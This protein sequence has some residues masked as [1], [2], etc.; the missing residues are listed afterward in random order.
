MPLIIFRVNSKLLYR[1]LVLYLFV[2]LCVSVFWILTTAESR[3]KVK[4]VNIFGPSVVYA[5]V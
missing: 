1:L 5:T 3:A 4:S 2:L